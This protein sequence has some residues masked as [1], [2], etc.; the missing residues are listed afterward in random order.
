METLRIIEA[1]IAEK[2]SRNEFP[3]VAS[4][5]EVLR[6]GGTNDELWKLEEQGLVRKGRMINDDYFLITEYNEV[7]S[8]M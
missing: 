3:D 8:R 2:R 7:N 1:I 5:Y 6:R 4:R